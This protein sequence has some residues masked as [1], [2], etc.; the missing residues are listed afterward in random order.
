MYQQTNVNETLAFQ[1]DA[2]NEFFA[3]YYKA[4]LRTA[5]RILRS[6]KDSVMQLRECRARPQLALD[7][8]L[9]ALET[10]AAPPEALCYL[11]ALRG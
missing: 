5:H 3:Q 8:I 2:I 6:E 7:D 9:L 10:H 1:G 4:S 11:A